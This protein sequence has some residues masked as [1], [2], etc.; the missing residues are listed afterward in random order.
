M[1]KLKLTKS[2]YA[3]L[4]LVVFTPTY[5]TFSRSFVEK[6]RNFDT[7]VTVFFNEINPLRDL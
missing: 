4:L 2:D 3:T 6:D 7:K 1:P 5:T